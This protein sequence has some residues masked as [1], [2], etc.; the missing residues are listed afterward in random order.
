MGGR[1]DQGCPPAEQPRVPR[2]SP[3][4]YEGG[5]SSVKVYRIL[6]FFAHLLESSMDWSDNNNAAS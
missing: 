4:L 1:G 6:K 5:E 2:R 3:R